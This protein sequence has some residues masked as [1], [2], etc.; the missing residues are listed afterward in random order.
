MTHP[1]RTAAH[2]PVLPVLE[3]SHL[4]VHYEERPALADISLALYGGEIV[5]LLGPNGAGK[6]TL[7]KVLAGM[8]SA[9]HGTVLYRGNP[10]RG[11][12]PAITYVPQR[13][14]ADWAFPISVREAV[15]LGL[16]HRTPRWRGFDRDEQR[17][18]M[19][20]LDHVG[21]Q[22]LAHVQIGELSGGQQQ[23]VFLARALLACGAVLLLDEP[24]TGVDIPTQDLFGSIF[25]DLRRR[26]TLVVYATHDLAQARHSSDRVVLINRHLIASGPPADTMVEEP[27]RRAFGGQVIVVSGPPLD[28]DPA[29][30]DQMARV[31][32]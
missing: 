24:F 3:T 23:R 4:T 31:S 1:K 25:A 28:T 19:D 10:L 29:P 13:S 6:S 8:L 17:R 22:E 20:A 14:G 15:L 21:I 2:V 9:S 26:G 16:S 5:G 7:L 11:T 30:V 12:H 32:R 27:L 18:A